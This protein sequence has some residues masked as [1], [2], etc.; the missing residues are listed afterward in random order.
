[1]IVG[2]P[3]RAVDQPGATRLGEL[4]RGRTLQRVLQLDQKLGGKESSTPLDAS[5][6][7]ERLRLEAV[8]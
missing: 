2:R 3:G 5:P 1:M 6:E 4:L 7:T 8:E